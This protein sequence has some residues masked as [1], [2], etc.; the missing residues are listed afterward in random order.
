MSCIFIVILLGFGG[1]VFLGCASQQ[2]WQTSVT[3]FRRQLRL[4]S[5]FGRLVPHGRV[6]SEMKVGSEHKHEFCK[7]VGISGS[8]AAA[9]SSFLIG[10]N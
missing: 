7:D 1:L 3:W 10:R 4:G 9:Q 2:I 8:L 6:L 5:A